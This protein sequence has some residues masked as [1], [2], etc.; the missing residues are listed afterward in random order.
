[1]AV[2]LG[3]AYGARVTA[4]AGKTHHETVL[5]LGAD[6]V[7]DYR[8]TSPR[9]L[10]RFDVVLDTVGTDLRAYRNLLT[11]T[12][13]MVAVAFDINHA[14]RSLGYLLAAKVLAPRRIHFFSGNPK[15]ALFADLA[16]LTE[17]GAISPVVDTV[18]PLAD[19]ARAHETLET[20]SVKGK[21]VIQVA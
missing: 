3:H 15:T 13:R 21:L 14:A 1:V 8:T 2:Q 6:E 10:P 17:S 7:F 4:L 19:I 16:H 12:G 9:D 5:A 20:T 18:F 11:P